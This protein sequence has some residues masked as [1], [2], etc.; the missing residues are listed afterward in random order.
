MSNGDGWES[1]FQA[2]GTTSP[3]TVDVMLAQRRA[4]GGATDPFAPTAAGG[5]GDRQPGLYLDPT[6]GLPMMRYYN[7]FGELV[8]DFLPSSYLDLLFGTDGGGGAAGP[9]WR[10]GE[11]ELALA[12]DQR[13]SEW[14]DYQMEKDRLDR[15]D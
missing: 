2:G 11:Y 13:E 15:L 4:F 1:L 9:S 14:Q 7:Q 6:S 3:P 12:A 10:P 5:D 8:E